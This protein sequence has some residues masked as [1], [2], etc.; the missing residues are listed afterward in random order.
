MKLGIDF[1]TTRTVVACCDRGNYPIVTFEDANENPVDWFPSVVAERRGELRFGFDAVAVANDRE[2]TLLRS[3]KRLLSGP[4]SGAD[5]DVPIGES[6]FAGGDLITRFLTA[7]REAIRTRSNCPRKKNDKE[8]VAVVATPAN[9]HGAQRFVTLDAFR[10]AGFDVAGLLNEP[11]AAGFEY[12]HRYRGTIT[13]K[14]EHIL[15]YDLGG[16]T[17]DASL[18]HM[19][20]KSHDA[21]ATAG[22]NHIGGD[23]FDSILVAQA[24]E[25]AGI[26]EHEVSP[27]AL[28]RLRD[29]CRDAKEALNPSSKRIVL[30]LDE[31][32]GPGPEGL[33]SGPREV[34]V[35]VAEYFDRCA[36][37]VQK[38]LDAMAPVLLRL[39][40]RLT[41][42]GDDPLAELA[43]LYVVGGASAL[44]VVGRV[45][46][47]AFGRRVHRS[48]YPSGAI[49]IGLAIA[50]DG[51]AGFELKDRLSRHFGVFREG[52]AGRE[53]VFDSIFSRETEVPRGE[54][55]AA[56]H[57]RVYRAAHN[58]GRY[59]FVEC[60]SLDA[61]GVP[62]GDITAYRDVLFPFDA[63]MRKRDAKELAALPVRRMSAEGPLIE[64]EYVVTPHGLV[65]VT[66]RDLESGFARAY[67]VGA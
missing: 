61:S 11:S 14:R 23:D 39:D 35:P 41:K 34:T 28:S 64:E 65:R 57:K 52:H 3:F 36:P 12:A 9:A 8:L 43:G 21:I 31:A 53:V 6:T 33:A 4:S 55:T 30:D 59:R 15:V 16:G 51:A 24:L 18:V 5:L 66:I 27:G 17:F 32:F 37:L 50:G 40:A 7:L 58:I 60:A 45:L 47:E 48:A 19:A 42:K 26:D 63:A 62:L 56:V 13:S 22:T 38:T 10:R 44:P 25:L 46:R 67:E 49:A 2:W 20:G 1:G 29:R 54:A